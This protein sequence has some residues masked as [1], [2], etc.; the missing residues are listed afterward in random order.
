MRLLLVCMIWGGVCVSPAQ[1][2]VCGTA[3]GKT[4]LGA[5]HLE[6]TS[7]YAA[8][9]AGFELNGSPA[10]KDGFC[11]G[12]KPF[13]FSVPLAEGSYRVTIRFGS[14]RAA[15]SGIGAQTTGRDR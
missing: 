11:T 9:S 2:F 8:T 14:S 6:S 1:Q 10:V 4:E 15:A 3:A 7:L 13:F 12:D 5:I